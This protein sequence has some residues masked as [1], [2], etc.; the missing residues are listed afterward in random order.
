MANMHKRNPWDFQSV[1]IYLIGLRFSHG[2]AGNKVD[3]R[4]RLAEH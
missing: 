1:Q 3:E 2:I 4:K